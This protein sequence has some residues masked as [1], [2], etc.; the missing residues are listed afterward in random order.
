MFWPVV[1]GWRE[2]RALG[3]RLYDRLMRDCRRAG[4][5]TTR[6]GIHSLRKTFITDLFRAGVNIRVVQR[7][8]RHARIEQTLA[9]YVEVFPWD[10]PAAIERLSYAESLVGGK[11]LATRC[12]ASPQADTA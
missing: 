9:V 12:P 6:V 7:L 2:R 10:E 1:T 11:Q 3:F 8:A 4:I 5:D